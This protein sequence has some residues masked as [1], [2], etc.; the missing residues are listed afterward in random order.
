MIHNEKK[1]QPIKSNLELTQMLELSKKNIR[2]VTITVFQMAKV[3]QRHERYL[4]KR[5]KLN[6]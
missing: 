6:F 2:A 1:N 4:L 5:A 3:K